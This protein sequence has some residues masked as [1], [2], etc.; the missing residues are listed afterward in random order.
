MQEVRAKK[1]EVHFR[2]QQII[3]GFIVD[4]YCCPSVPSGTPSRSTPLGAPKYDRTTVVFG[5]GRWGQK[6]EGTRLEKVCSSL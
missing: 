5:G 1:L 2:R 3:Q 4:F 6:E